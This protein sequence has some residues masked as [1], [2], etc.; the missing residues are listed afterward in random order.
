M[1]DQDAKTVET[2]QEAPPQEAA[3]E[4][5][6]PAGDIRITAATP[7]YVSNVVVGIGSTCKGSYNFIAGSNSYA[8]GNHNVINGY[9]VKVFGSGC[10][11]IGSDVTVYGNNKTVIGS[12]QHYPTDAPRQHAMDLFAAEMRRIY[13]SNKKE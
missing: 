6:K 3:K 10:T 8:E 11:V 7:Q 2:P 1:S 12:I 5:P 9:N 4:T 13:D